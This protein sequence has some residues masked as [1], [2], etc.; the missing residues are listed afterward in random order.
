M[1]EEFVDA[2]NSYYKMKHNYEDKYQSQKN[3]IIK[4][5]LLNKKEKRTKLLA[6]KRTCV[7]CKRMVG[8]IF[9][10]KDGVLKAICGD[11]ET[12]CD[13]QIELKK[14]YFVNVE[15][16]AASQL[17]DSKMSKEAVITTKL[18]LLFNYLTEDEAIE[19][20]DK[21]RKELAEELELY[22]K[23]RM[24]YLNVTDNS[25]KKIKIKN[26]N[27][28][29][30]VSIER[31]KDLMQQYDE[32]ENI[33]LIKDVLSIYVDIQP[34]LKELMNT[35]Y[36]YNNVEYNSN[37]NTYHLIQNKYTLQELEMPYVEPETISNKK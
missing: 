37:D 27:D 17:D 19:N 32:T 31:I 23:F 5:P 33:G 28:E 11:I 25:E 15:T 29:L 8:T 1:S 13:L 4:N 26:L 30:F 7:K 34:K 9:S 35:K 10:N 22:T 2:L 21:F 6:L 36:A 20:F 24:L 16:E 18:D 14:G 3:K 12:P